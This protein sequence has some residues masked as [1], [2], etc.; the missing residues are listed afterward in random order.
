[1]VEPVR[2]SAISKAS[3]VGGGVVGGWL[4]S[5]VGIALMGT[6]I[7]GVLPLAAVGAGVSWLATRNVRK[8]PHCGKIFRF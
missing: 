4:G 5:S 2:V 1:M 3:T 6:A 8:C 7:S